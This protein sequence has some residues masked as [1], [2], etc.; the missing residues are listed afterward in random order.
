[1]ASGPRTVH[2]RTPKAVAKAGKPVGTSGAAPEK[3]VTT[4]AQREVKESKVT[5]IAVVFTHGQGEQTPMADVVELAQSLWTTA[6]D[7]DLP[8]FERGVWSAPVFDADMSEQRRLVTGEFPI[9][10]DT[11]QVDFYQFYWADL[12]TGNR[13]QHLWVW[14]LG[15][16]KRKYRTEK[17]DLSAAR[18]DPPPT[19]P[20]G[21]VVDETPPRLRTIRKIA[22]LAAGVLAVFGVLFGAA[23]SALLFSPHPP[24]DRAAFT[25]FGLLFTWGS[26]FSL[27]IGVA[28]LYVLFR[29]ARRPD[30]EAALRGALALILAC[31]ALGPFARDLRGGVP[32]VVWSAHLAVLWS[33]MVGATV[34]GLLVFWFG[35]RKL[36]ESFLTP[37]MTDSARLLSATPE[38]I[39][40]RD[41]IRKRG[42]DLLDALHTSERRYDRIVVLAHSLGTVVAYNVLAQYWG[43][44][45]RLFD[46]KVCAQAHAA[47]TLAGAGLASNGQPRVGPE[48]VKALSAFRAAVRDYY[49]VLTSYAARLPLGDVE[50]RA[51]RF[52]ASDGAIREVLDK[53]SDA[54]PPD[55]ASYRAPWRVSDFITIGSPLTYASLLMAERDAELLE[56]VEARRY[57]LSPP[58][59]GKIDQPHHASL[60]GATVW[61][62]LHFRTTGLVKGDLIGGQ[63]A[64]PPPKGLGLG[65]MDVTL[66]VSAAMPQFAHS[67]YWRWPADKTTGVTPPPHIV[68]LRAALNLFG[69]SG[70]AVEAD[71]IAADRASG[72]PT[73][74]RVSE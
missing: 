48:R 26:F 6:P 23:T 43:N 62:N 66:P 40:N 3:T 36:N 47:M 71:L 17:P 13:F 12:M 45:Y 72:E 5:R 34:I 64:G 59:P 60:F 10:G 25:L 30:R 55:E 39:P 28:T 49:A 56:W 29:L 18:G 74:D 37:V 41:K 35:L 70:S 53:V 69:R 4:E 2:T 73:V 27:L 63:I 11:L 61:T 8:P 24:P 46:R 31:L 58:N 54:P 44:V 67:E 22:M 7:T 21:T 33:L 20:P 15:L 52:N 38:N 68:A 1:M 32:P 42:M 51:A 16:M 65:I 57:P 9:G 19:I 50:W 14:F